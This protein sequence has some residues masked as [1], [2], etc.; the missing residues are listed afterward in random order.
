MLAVA[1][2]LAASVAYGISDFLGGL[3]SRSVAL[4]P[5][6]L[7]SQG[8]A[9]ILLF[10]IVVSRGEGPPGGAFLLYGAIA[11]LSEMVGVAALY[12]G[13]AVG[14]MSI[15]AGVGATAPVVAVVVGIVL[16]ELPTPIQG[17]GIVLAVSGIILTS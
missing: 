6:L 3:T 2:A 12:R 15:I 17:V 4:L 13:L 9:L 8:T 14:V 16:G 5:V 11:G 10:M 7:V 1:L